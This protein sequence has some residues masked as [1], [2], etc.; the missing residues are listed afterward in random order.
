MAQFLQSLDIMA[1]E[2]VGGQ[3]MAV[4]RT[5]TMVRHAISQDV[6]RGHQDAVPH[7]K[8]GLLRPVA[9]Q[10]GV[11]GDPIHPPGAAGLPDTLHPH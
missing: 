2:P 8:R 10:P 3:A 5:T 11:L 1:R 4:G 7:G 9:L 6:I